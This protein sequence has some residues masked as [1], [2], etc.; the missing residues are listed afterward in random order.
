MTPDR[1]V[2][3]TECIGKLLLAEIR[4]QSNV[5]NRNLGFSDIFVKSQ[6]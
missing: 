6:S 3:L 5:S 2:Y 4:R 1:D